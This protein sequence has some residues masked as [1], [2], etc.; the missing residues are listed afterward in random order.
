MS[1][2]TGMQR[3]RFTKQEAENKLGR[4]VR[5]LVPLPAVPQGTTGRVVRAEEINDGY[6]LVIEWDAGVSNSRFQDWFT[7][8]EYENNLLEI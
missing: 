8:D 4:A 6:D 2:E 5:S 1:R 7:K 3:Q